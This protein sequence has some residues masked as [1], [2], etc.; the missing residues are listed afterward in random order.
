LRAPNPS[1]PQR[2]GRLHQPFAARG[3]TARAVGRLR[4]P[5]RARTAGTG[6]GA[7]SG[8]RAHGL[9]A[10]R[11]AWVRTGT[12]A[13]GLAGRRERSGCARTH[14]HGGGTRRGYGTFMRLDRKSTRLNSSHVKISYAVFC[15]K[16]KRYETYI[17]YAHKFAHFRRKTLVRGPI[18]YNITD[19][20]KRRTS[21]NQALLYVPTQNH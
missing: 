12:R 2:S 11:E 6:R 18:L 16:K 17:Y 1:A 10:R 9:L 3:R 21:I 20:T 4:V 19:I 13:R 15:L 7:G 5:R 8:N 14:A